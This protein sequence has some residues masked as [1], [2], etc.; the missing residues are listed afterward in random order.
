MLSQTARNDIACHGSR[1]HISTVN[2]TSNHFASVLDL[3]R[4]A[5]PP[6]HPHHRCI[7]LPGLG[8]K[9]CTWLKNVPRR[10]KHGRL[11][12]DVPT[13]TLIV[14]HRTSNIFF[15]QALI[16][17]DQLR[18]YQSTDG[19]YSELTVQELCFLHK[20]RED[21]CHAET[22][23]GTG[24]VTMEFSSCILCNVNGQHV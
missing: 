5:I 9:R 11:G 24:L 15:P 18:V 17:I 20:W 14:G 2:R 6:P 7:M 12:G 3:R 13:T 19:D 22:I 23:V 16:T 21:L 10:G 1:L 4:C 8:V